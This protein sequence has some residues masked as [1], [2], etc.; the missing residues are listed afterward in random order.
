[1]YPPTYLNFFSP[2]F[3]HRLYTIRYVNRQSEIVKF[4]NSI[5]Q[6]LS[7]IIIRPLCKVTP[8]YLFTI[9]S[10]SSVKKKKWWHFFL[11]GT[12]LDANRFVLSVVLIFLCLDNS[13]EGWKGFSDI[14]FTRSFFQT[15]ILIV[16]SD[17][18][19][20]LLLE[21]GCEIFIF[22]LF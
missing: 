12:L 17:G 20:D 10:V 18:I 22:L 21:F 5:Y 11:Y 13:V 16:W 4:Y 14:F 7:V 6:Y 3:F 9:V 2:N 8:F 1:M 15:F 19:G